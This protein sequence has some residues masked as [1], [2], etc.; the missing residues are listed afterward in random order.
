MTHDPGSA[1]PFAWFEGWLVSL[2]IAQMVVRVHDD[3]AGVHPRL[4]VHD[5]CR[6]DRRQRSGTY[7]HVSSNLW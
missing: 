2:K 3:H 1:I 5:G 4:G 6:L 7:G